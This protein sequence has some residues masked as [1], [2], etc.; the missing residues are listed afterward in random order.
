MIARDLERMLVMAQAS[1]S[2]LDLVLRSLRDNG[3]IPI[4]GRGTN[5]PK[6]GNVEASAIL[7][8]LAASDVAG[9]SY[10]ALA[11]LRALRFA[12]SSVSARYSESLIDTV[13]SLLGDPVLANGVRE[14]RVCRNL[15][16]AEIFYNDGTVERFVHEDVLVDAAG[17]GGACFRSEGV[18][19]GGLLTTVALKLKT[20]RVESGWV[21]DTVEADQRETVHA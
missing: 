8:A 3:A 10:L 7:L 9:K 13:R 4:G 19:S 11:G 1:P 21:G 5:A 2:G 18:L 6:I 20:P 14:I 15:P 17:F 16:L 12:A